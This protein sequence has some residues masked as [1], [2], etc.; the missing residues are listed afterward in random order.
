MHSISS[1]GSVRGDSAQDRLVDFRRV[2]ALIGSRC[3]TGHIARKYAREGLICAVRINSRVLRYS[4]AS[5]IAFIEKGK[6]QSAAA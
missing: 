5:V 2:N 1:T 6:A 3:V 4:E